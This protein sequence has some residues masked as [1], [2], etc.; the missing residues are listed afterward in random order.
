MAKYELTFLLSEEAESKKIKELLESLAVKVDSEENWGQ[1]TLAYRV[2]KNHTAYFYN[3]TLDVDQTK[4]AELKR[5]LN[6]HEKLLRYLLL[7]K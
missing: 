6:F 2:K 7:T 5:R 1:K 3:W 4:V